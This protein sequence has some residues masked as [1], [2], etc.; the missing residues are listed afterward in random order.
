MMTARTAG[1]RGGHGAGL[2]IRGRGLQ[3]Q[4]R[5]HSPDH[6]LFGG[7]ARSMTTGEPSA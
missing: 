6:D 4:V 7:R 2:C 5:M 1:G 3:K